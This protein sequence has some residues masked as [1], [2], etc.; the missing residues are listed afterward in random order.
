MMQRSS[1]RSRGEQLV[2]LISTLVAL[3]WGTT[4]A[5]AEPRVGGAEVV[6]F[7]NDGGWC[8]FE[9]PRAIVQEGKLIMGTVA[10]GRSDPGRRGDIEA[11]VFDLKKRTRTVCELHDQLQAD[12]HNSPVFLARGDGR[13]LTVYA[14]HGPEN[15][16]YYRISAPN[17]PTKWGPVETYVPSQSTRLTYQNL[18]QLSGETNRIYNFFRGLDSSWKPSFVY[19]DDGGESWRTGNVV[20]RSPAARPYVRYASDGAETIHLFY[21][22][23][24]PRDFNNSVYHIFY[25]GGGLHRTDGTRVATLREGINNPNEGTRIFQGDADHVA[26]CSDIELDSDGKPYVAYSVQTGSAGLP[27]GQGGGDH[28][29]RY[30]RWDGREWRDHQMAFAGTRLY[31]GEDDYTGLAALDPNDP[32]RV[33]ISTN[34]DPETGAPL[35]SSAD[36]KR[37]WEIFQGATNDGGRSWTW[38]PITKNSSQD[39]LRPIKPRSRDYDILL[40]LRGEY[41]SYTD[42]SLEVVGIVDLVRPDSPE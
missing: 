37:H 26:W 8:W 12:D 29:Y 33:Y 1:K 40:W 16:F 15:R 35:I 41:R 42:Y 10:N 17:D 6:V 13:I 28:R 22:E 32:N 30:A 18:F 2:V 21:T 23:G 11:V 27:S 7:S 36:G 20:I 3:G 25:R 9:D 5:G 4:V 14:K 19:S 24:H 38:A 31:A 34:A 39:N